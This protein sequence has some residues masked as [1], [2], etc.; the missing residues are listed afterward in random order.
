MS[1]RTNPFEELERLFDR[2]G[3][4]FDDATQVWESD[5]PLSRPLGGL[6]GSPGTA[7]DLVDRETEFVAMV[8]L[9]GF[10]REDIEVEVTDHRL[11]IAAER[12]ET[13][14]EENERYIRRERRRK[15]TERSI[16]L[17]EEID[18]D[19]VEARMKNGVLEITL[20]KLEVAE[21]HTIDIQ[22]D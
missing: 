1:T 12:E 15:S 3:R 14:D 22:T 4:Q 13:A 9:P 21:A 8:D 11:N 19:G 5:G 17:P 10:E 20:P 2:M 18:A 7:V 6:A 16:R